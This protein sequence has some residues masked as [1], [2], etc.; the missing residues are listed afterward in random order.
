MTK[1]GYSLRERKK[2]QSVV[3]SILY[4]FQLPP[5]EDWSRRFQQK[6][7]IREKPKWT[8]YLEVHMY[9]IIDQD[10]FRNSKS[11][12]PESNL[13]CWGISSPWA[14]VHKNVAPLRW[15]PTSFFIFPIFFC[16]TIVNS[17][18]FIV[19]NF[20][21]FVVVGTA[22]VLWLTASPYTVFFQ[23]FHDWSDNTLRP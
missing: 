21:L 2:L 22:E 14:N 23:T 15:D 5:N 7:A 9:R 11:M 8:S 20:T 12:N 6:I 13:S 16:R 18:G 3:P 19:L 17:N 1:P 10:R 4:I